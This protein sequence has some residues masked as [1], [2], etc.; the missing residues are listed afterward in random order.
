MMKQLFSKFQ[1][2][3]PLTSAVVLSWS[4]YFLC[5]GLAPLMYC[6]L[7]TYETSCTAKM[8][9]KEK[10]KLFGYKQQVVIQLFIDVSGHEFAPLEFAQQLFS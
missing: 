1:V 10:S 4:E 5:L 3:F 6:H 7:Y 8:L 2:A 9:H